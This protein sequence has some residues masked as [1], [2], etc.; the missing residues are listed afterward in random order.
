MIRRDDGDDWI[1]IEQI[2]HANLAAAIVRAWGNERV[3]PLGLSHPSGLALYQAV[4]HHDDGWSEW[5]WAPRLDPR[6]G[7]RTLNAGKTSA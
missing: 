2:K 4:S 3:E 1:I 7:E 6:T 5:D